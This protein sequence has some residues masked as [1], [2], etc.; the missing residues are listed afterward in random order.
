[1]TRV[2]RIEVPAG[3][4]NVGARGDNRER[5]FWD[6][7]D[8]RLYLALLGQVVRRHAWTLLT[9]VLMT[10]HYHLLF[11]IDRGGLS[12]GMQDLNGCFARTM[13]RRHGRVGHLF[14][15]R[16][17]DELVGSDRHLLA[18]VRYIVLNP[19]RAG[20]CRRPEQWPWSSHRA[21]LGLDHP[22]TG[23]AVGEVLGLFGERPVDARRAYR[24]FVLEGLEGLDTVPGTVTEM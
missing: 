11:R 3:T 6:D 5:I 9:Y 14:E 8:R 10:N 2:L 4:Y 22:I 23:L 16:F 20:I 17:Y 24:R 1:M 19:V 7:A 12:D 18:A 21:V 13:N 15:R